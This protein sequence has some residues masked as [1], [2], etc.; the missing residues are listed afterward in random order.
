MI[1]LP[2]TQFGS[3]ILMTTSFFSQGILRETLWIIS[4]HDSFICTNLVS[5]GA[6]S[7]LE[8]IR[9][10]LKFMVAALCFSFF[11]FFLCEIHFVWENIMRGEQLLF[12]N[13]SIITR[14]L[15]VCRTV[16]RQ[17]KIN[18]IPCFDC[19]SFWMPNFLTFPLPSLSLYFFNSD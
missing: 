8:M 17:L 18:R 2:A 3:S 11:F 1:D 15:K 16:I 13:P 7:V 4:G 10:W 19:F 12:N 6:R 5:P 14:F 9:S